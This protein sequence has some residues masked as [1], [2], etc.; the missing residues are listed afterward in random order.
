MKVVLLCSC[1]ERWPELVLEQQ[2]I[3]AGRI[4]HHWCFKVAVRLIYAVLNLEFL[5][6]R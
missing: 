6:M 2:P 1:P 4:D 3:W 5:N